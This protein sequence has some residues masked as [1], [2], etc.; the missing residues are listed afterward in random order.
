[1]SLA[2]FEVRTVP[3]VFGSLI[4]FFFFFPVMWHGIVS[5]I[6]WGTTCTVNPYLGLI[7]PTCVPVQHTDKAMP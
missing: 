5:F 7:Y 4:K 6:F 1:M 3:S 2:V